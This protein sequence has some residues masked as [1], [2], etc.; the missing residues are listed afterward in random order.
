MMDYPSSPNANRN[1]CECIST[2]IVNCKTNMP[3]LNYLKR[4]ENEN[5]QAENYRN[6]NC[7]FDRYF[8]G[9]DSFYDYQ[10]ESYPFNDISNFVLNNS[11]SRDS[12][13][14]SG[15]PN[16]FQR[17]NNLT[18]QPYIIDH[19]D[20]NEDFENNKP[21][22]E[23]RKIDENDE[24]TQN[25]N[26]NKK[27]ILK[28]EVNFPHFFKKNKSSKTKKPFLKTRAEIESEISIDKSIK[29]QNKLK[30]VDVTS[31]S[32]QNSMKEKNNKNTND[33][34]NFVESQHDQ[35]KNE[36]NKALKEKTT[37]VDT[38]SQTCL[39][40]SITEKVH[41]QFENGNYRQIE[42]ENNNLYGIKR[43][44]SN[45][46]TG[47]L[48]PKTSEQNFQ[49]TQQTIQSIQNND[50]SKLTMPILNIKIQAPSD[51]NAIYNRNPS[52]TNN[53]DNTH[54]SSFPDTQQNY[55]HSF[56]NNQR[57][58]LQTFQNN[59][60]T[61]QP[62]FQTSYPPQRQQPIP[63]S[64]QPQ[65][66]NVQ[67]FKHPQLQTVQNI[68]SQIS[69]VQN[70]QPQ[71]STVQNMNF[72][73]QSIQNDQQQYQ[74]IQTFNG[75]QE[76]NQH[77]IA[78]VHRNEQC[79]E[80]K[81]QRNQFTQMNDCNNIQSIQQPHQ[82]SSN[83]LIQ[84][85]SQ[86]NEKIIDRSQKHYPR[87]HQSLGDMKSYKEE[88]SNQ[89][90]KQEEVE[91]YFRSLIVY[92]P[93]LFSSAMSDKTLILNPY[94][95]KLEP[96][97]FWEENQNDF[98][99]EKLVNTFFRIDKN[100]V[101]KFIY[102]LYDMLLITKKMPML[103]GIIGVNWIT[104]RIFSVNV[105]CI[106]SMLNLVPSTADFILF[107]ENQAFHQHGFCEVTPDN[108]QMAGLGS[109]P[110]YQENGVK[111]LFH[112]EHKFVDKELSLKELDEIDK[113]LYLKENNKI[114]RKITSKAKYPA[115]AS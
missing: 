95:L 12:S 99:F 41:F 60:Q 43:D 77:V 89:N 46:E 76:L 105:N 13:N 65:Q 82:P 96:I 98:T 16:L 73:Q 63:S 35:S 78:K 93:P 20:Q 27:M 10:K 51:G 14:H 6:C 34:S 62:L 90:K 36:S 11:E 53:A 37:N 28:E 3:S 75:H 111:F 21:D 108:Y 115:F 42:S 70:I 50:R 102:K 67:T 32:Q 29:N 45:D 15:Y 106:S 71:I 39:F 80:G 87:D 58:P 88:L 56:Q 92:E 48:C 49:C 33:N 97:S 104:N 23:N 24:F 4:K 84:N 112:N 101:A 72:R 38:S 31:Q 54:I 113:K 47:N 103:K 9:Q 30:K 66:Q 85:N 61:P 69:T 44:S 59:R 110:E 18:K 91:L 100:R 79:M 52:L 81:Y 55:Q 107:G 74:P 1:H 57:P 5:I 94:Q 83:H 8:N 2:E 17:S 19:N 114:N 7:T 40:S 22:L 25:K 86:Y 26:Q 64:Y 109:F 68:Q